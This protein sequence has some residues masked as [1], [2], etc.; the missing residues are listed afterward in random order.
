[1]GY[2]LKNVH[3]YPP[4]L[5]VSKEPVSTHKCGFQIPKKS[6][7]RP[8]NHQFFAGSFMKTTSSL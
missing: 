7:D 4:V 2:Q 6:K 8:E 5:K 1:M 3:T